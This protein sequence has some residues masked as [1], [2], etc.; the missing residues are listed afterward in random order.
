MD[1]DE[2]PEELK[3]YSGDIERSPRV[4]WRGRFGANTNRGAFFII[5]TK[6]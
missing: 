1:G 5:G 6:P 2:N 3:D 4:W